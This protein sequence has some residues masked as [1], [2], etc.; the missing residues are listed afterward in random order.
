MHA[1]KC[2]HSNDPAMQLLATRSPAICQIWDLCLSFRELHA[3]TFPTNNHTTFVSAEHALLTRLFKGYHSST[4][5]PHFRFSFAYIN[6]R[7][8]G[9]NHTQL[10]NPQ[11]I[12]SVFNLFLLCLTHLLSTLPC[13]SRHISNHKW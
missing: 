1:F 8:D 12:C 13:T 9:F 2:M 3:E 5:L 11:S 10:L 6:A 4:S 7:S